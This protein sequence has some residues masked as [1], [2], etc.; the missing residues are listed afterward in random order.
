M[1]WVRKP[2]NTKLIQ[3]AR[4]A[5]VAEELAHIDYLRAV[6]E[7]VNAMNQTQ[8][9]EELGISQPAVSQT[10]KTAETLEPVPQGFS[11]SSCAE[12][13]KRYIA[14]HITR[15]ALVRELKE[16]MVLYNCSTID[17]I[18]E[19]NSLVDQKLM[20]PT[21]GQHVIALIDA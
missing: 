15:P 6:R 19:I 8:V 18:A 9:A 20:N 12:I 5:R 16:W 2:V 21:T 17:I 13:V 11:G 10:L 4:R 1:G 14:G 7:G 3:A